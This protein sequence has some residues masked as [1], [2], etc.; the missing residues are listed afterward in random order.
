M[1]RKRKRLERRKIPKTCFVRRQDKKKGRP[2]RE[3]ECKKP[4][5]RGRGKKKE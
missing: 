2:S 3:F 1:S 4:G 5:T